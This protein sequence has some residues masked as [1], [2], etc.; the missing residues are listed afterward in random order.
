MPKPEK[1]LAYENAREQFGFRGGS[2]AYATARSVSL[3]HHVRHWMD[4]LRCTEQGA[5]VLPF[6][7]TK[8]ISLLFT[9]LFIC[10]GANCALA[11]NAESGIAS[12]TSAPNA[13]SPERLASP[14]LIPWPSAGLLQWDS[15][16][17]LKLLR[18]T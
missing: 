5:E 18:G 4:S 15:S 2:G 11:V 9:V 7:K 10:L 6:L 13:Q 12:A 14:S 1:Q 17:L 8:L 16:F 3:L